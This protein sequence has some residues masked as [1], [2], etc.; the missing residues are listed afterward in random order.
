CVTG[1][2]QG[3]D[4]LPTASPTAA[5]S[6]KTKSESGVASDSQEAKPAAT[7]EPDFWHRE[8][9][10]GNW[11]GTRTRWKES[12]VELEFKLSQFYQGVAVGGIRHDSE[13]NGK[14]Q[15]IAKF[16][17]GKL[18]GWKYW[19]ADVRTETRFGGPLLGG[20]GTINPTNTAEMI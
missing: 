17:L 8:T 5:T 9:M 10:T 11:G 13:Y 1:F 19:Y 20:T 4:P 16:D 18:A 7:P 2:A 14:F 12:G 6:D 3:P 15:T